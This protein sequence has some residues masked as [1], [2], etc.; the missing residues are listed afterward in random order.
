MNIDELNH[1]VIRNTALP[2]VTNSGLVDEQPCYVAGSDVLTGIDGTVRRRPGF[3][4]YTADDFGANNTIRRYFSWQRW[5]GAY[6]VIVNVTDSSANSSKV[7]KQKIGTDAAFVLLTTSAGNTNPFFF[8][9]G[10]NYMFYGNGTDMKKYDGTT[11]TS[12]GVTCLTTAP[13]LVN[14]G[15]GN[16]PGVIGHT[17][18]AAG[19]NSTSGYIT[20]ISNPSLS[21]SAASRTWTVSAVAYTDTYIDKIHVYRTEDGGSIWR[22]LSNSPIANPGTG[23][24]SIADNDADASLQ[25]VL[26]PLAG[27]NAAPT[28]S[29]PCEQLYASR[30]FTWKDDTLG[31]SNLEEST[32]NLMQEEGFAT[33]N[34]RRFGRQIT[35]VAVAGDVL[36]I[37][38]V[39]GIFTLTGYSSTTWQWG[40][41]SRK[42]GLR[43]PHALASDGKVCAWLDVNNQVRATDGVNI[44]EPDLSLPIRPDL[45]AIVHT[46]A[47]MAI[48]TVGKRNYIM[49]ADGGASK[50]RVYDLDAK[51]WMPPWP[52]SNTA[53]GL[54][55][56]AAGTWNLLIGSAISGATTAKPLK[57]D[58]TNAVFQDAGT[59]YA[60][61][62][63]TGLLPIT[64]PTN[65]TNAEVLFFIGTERSND[66]AFS[67]VR[68]LLD[69]DPTQGTFTSIFTTTISTNP[70]APTRRS[71][72]TYLIEEY[73]A[74]KLDTTARRASIKLDWAA[75]N[76]A[77]ILYSFDLIHQRYS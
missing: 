66:A 2:Y 77:A 6:Y 50:I 28:A 17:Y 70:V 58:E 64:T 48:Y 3:P 71:F 4:V 37:Y 68:F 61:S 24:W 42:Y 38:T 47:S 67:N 29:Y 19:G 21:T 60:P 7:Y 14:S 26:A 51:R 12:W 22:E 41:L 73:W 18:V 31:W 57:M 76:S 40:Q 35:R 16:V 54:V 11:V 1:N 27:I 23:S 72:K 36:L 43:G 62:I 63:T 9:V 10:H 45:T 39:S 75:A 25:T 49:L 52:I 30:V 13:T 69:D 53:I 34:K 33:N 15:A 20:D 5:D 56:T 46:S 8:V 32:N 59:S 65:P 55:E 44:T 74:T